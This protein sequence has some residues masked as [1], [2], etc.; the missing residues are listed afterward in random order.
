MIDTKAF[1]EELAGIVKAATQPLLARI[2]ALEKALAD[3]PQP[4]DGKDADPDEVEALVRSRIKPDIDRLHEAVKG[5]Y[6]LPPARPEIE[7]MVALSV[8]AAVAEIPIP[9]DGKSVDPVEVQRMVAEA[10]AAIPVPQDGKSIDPADI[11]AMVEDAVAAIP[12]PENGKDGTDG[13]DGTSVTV[14]DVLPTLQRHVD[15]YLA[16]LPVP[17]DGKDGVDGTDGKDGASVTADD[18]LP[19]LMERADAY[20]T[21]LPVPKDGRDGA[22]GKDGAPG[23]KGADGI[24]LAGALIDRTGNLVVTLTNGETK[25]L[26]EVVGRDGQAGGK[27]ADGIGF[28]DMTLDYDGERTFTFLFQKD[29]R[30]EERR[31]VVPV[32]L[33]RGVYRA[34]DG[35]AKGDAVTYGGSI[36]IAQR[37]TKARPDASADWRLSV[38]A[39]RNGKDGVMKVAPDTTPIRVG[40]GHAG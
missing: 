4:R 14:D 1:G 28:D 17:K 7:A 18:V 6:E 20:L 22:D 16:S 23:E 5:H 25:A 8:K 26:G 32:V 3:R 24:G 19:V 34:D 13:K 36:W 11:K 2:D 40:G 37:E 33:D 39:G 30:I 15:G 9:Q 35:Y 29:G 21:S 38:K 10:V 31:F 27:G 12:T